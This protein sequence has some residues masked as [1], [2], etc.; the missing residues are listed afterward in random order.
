MKAYF[1]A[2]TT[3]WLEY[4]VNIQLYNDAN[5]TFHF[6]KLRPRENRHHF[7]DDIF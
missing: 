2:L 7:A 5:T 3:Q 1:L 4:W 6:N